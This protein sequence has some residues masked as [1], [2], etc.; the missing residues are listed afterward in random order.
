[1]ET[2][3]QLLAKLGL[4]E[5][6]DPEY[7]TSVLLDAE[8]DDENRSSALLCLVEDIEAVDDGLSLQQ[9]CV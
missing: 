2:L 8:E 1:M 5:D 3:D 4:A 6:A 7:A 9:A